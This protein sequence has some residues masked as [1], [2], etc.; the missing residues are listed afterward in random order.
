MVFNP[1]AGEPAPGSVDTEQLVD[2][3]VTADKVEA[4]LA[5]SV[6]QAIDKTWNHTGT[7]DKRFEEFQFIKDS[8]AKRNLKILRVYGDL[9]SDGTNTATL[10]I[11]MDS[12]NG[13]WTDD[14]YTGSDTADATV[15]T[16][17]NTLA[18][19]TPIELDI[20]GLA[21]GKHTVTMSLKSDNGA[22]TIETE[23]R[24]YLPSK[25]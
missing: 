25:N 4:G 16:T 20:S 19:F 21:N 1:R 2:G 10:S 9:K 15:T 5:D 18:T 22:G 7:D 24:E 11:W 3:A 12:P 8:S 17:S 14:V 23:T 13:D 6:E